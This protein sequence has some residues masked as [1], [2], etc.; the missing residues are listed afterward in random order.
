MPPSWKH[1]EV[2]YALLSNDFAR[3]DATHIFILALEH[4]CSAV[5]SLC[6]C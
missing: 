2:Q 5:A 4:S 6:R 3:P 1:I